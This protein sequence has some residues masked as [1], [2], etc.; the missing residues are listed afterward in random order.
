MQLVS[1]RATFFR[2]KPIFCQK[3][4]EYDQCEVKKV[5]LLEVRFDPNEVILNIR[6]LRKLGKLEFGTFVTF[7]SFFDV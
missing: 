4:W 3:F 1:R 5:I 7:W 6:K 2:L